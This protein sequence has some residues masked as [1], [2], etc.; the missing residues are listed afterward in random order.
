MP[1]RKKAAGQTDR[2]ALQE[3]MERLSAFILLKSV[4]G[5]TGICRISV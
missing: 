3:Y 1:G 2:L 5:I 4:D